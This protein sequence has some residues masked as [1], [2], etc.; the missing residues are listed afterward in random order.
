MKEEWKEIPGFEGL[1]SVSNRGNVLS[2]RSGKLRVLCNDPNGYKILPLSKD[3]V[4]R[5]YRV[6]RLVCAAFYG[7]WSDTKTH[8]DHLDC[9]PSNND[10]SNLQI[11]KSK[12]NV[13]SSRIHPDKQKN[14]ASKYDNVIRQGK[15]WATTGI[16]RGKRVSKTFNDEWEAAVFGRWIRMYPDAFNKMIAKERLGNLKYTYFHKGNQK[17]IGTYSL[18]GKR[19]RGRYKATKEEAYFSLLWK[20]HELTIKKPS[21]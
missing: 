17:W 14:L 12:E 16:Y 8:I 15:K 20:I 3:G 2:H 10:I 19:I 7:V 13:S 11:V 18:N 6:H 5:N 9:D 4:A 21:I 1:Y